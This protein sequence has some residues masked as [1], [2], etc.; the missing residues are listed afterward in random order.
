MFSILV[1][2]DAKSN[3]ATL[4]AMLTGLLKNTLIGSFEIVEAIHGDN[5]VQKVTEKINAD[6]KNYNLIF[7]DFYMP[8]EE[9]LTYQDGAQATLG[10]R[11][12]EREFNLNQ[13]SVSKIVTYTSDISRLKPFPGSD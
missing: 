10:I 8:T 1:V 3:R 9:V 5:A 7:M 12:L 6:G 4:I 11:I 2:D 13:D